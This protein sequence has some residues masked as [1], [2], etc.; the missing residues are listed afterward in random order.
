M[1]SVVSFDNGEHKSRFLS[2]GF[3]KD[4]LYSDILS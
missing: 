2:K 1:V 4:S 3:S